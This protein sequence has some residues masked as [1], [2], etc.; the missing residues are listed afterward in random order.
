MTEILEI[1]EMGFTKDW[2]VLKIASKSTFA[3]FSGP[4]VDFS[5]IDSVRIKSYL[6]FIICKNGISYVK[7]LI[8]FR[9]DPLSAI[10]GWRQ[11]GQQKSCLKS[12]ENWVASSLWVGGHCYTGIKIR[13]KTHMSLQRFEVVSPFRPI[14]KSLRIYKGICFETK[15]TFA[16]FFQSRS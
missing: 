9:V 5:T 14:F 3:F 10:L 16:F 8:P 1:L 7:N 6:W 11:R 13:V 4:G 15:L 12:A 2:F